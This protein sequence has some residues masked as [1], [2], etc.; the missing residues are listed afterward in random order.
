MVIVTMGK[1]KKKSNNVSLREY[2]EALRA[3]DQHALQIKE[4]ADERALLLQTE[5][6][7]Y[8]DEKANELRSQI[9]SER[10]SYATQI[11]LRALNDKSEAARRP[12][13]EFVAAQQG[14]RS[15]TAWFVGV[16]LTLTTILVSLIAVIV[17]LIVK[18]HG[19]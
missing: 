14:G 18:T 10:G 1:N 19:G 12:L 5:T 7:K 11:E 6:Q 9:E 3:A 16:I 17:V 13:E 4:T 2:F 15:R 8:K